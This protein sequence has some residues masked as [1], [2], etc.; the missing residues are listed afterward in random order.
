MKLESDLQTYWLIGRQLGSYSLFDDKKVPKTIDFSLECDEKHRNQ[1]QS[2]AGQALQERQDK[3]RQKNTRQ[4]KRRQEPQE[5]H[6]RADKS[7][8]Q[9]ELNGATVEYR[10]SRVAGTQGHHPPETQPLLRN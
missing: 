4:D 5:E 6:T 7:T 8:R 9:R 10:I 1:D 2:R 3:T